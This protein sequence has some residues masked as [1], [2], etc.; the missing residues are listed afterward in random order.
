M[1]TQTDG[2]KLRWICRGGCALS[3]AHLLWCSGAGQRGLASLVAAD[4]H[5]HLSSSQPLCCPQQKIC[6]WLSASTR[7]MGQG[8]WPVDLPKYDQLTQIIGV[9]EPWQLQYDER[10]EQLFVTC[11]SSGRELLC[12]QQ[13]RGQPCPLAHPELC[14]GQTKAPA[15]RGKSI[16]SGRGRKKQEGL[17]AVSRDGLV[18]SFCHC[19]CTLQRDVERWGL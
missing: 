15:P 13:E 14:W 18:I 1:H 7:L 4:R 11:E 2:K 16:F 6:R 8:S 17:E 10:W 5:K 12:T 3:E 9:R 19:C